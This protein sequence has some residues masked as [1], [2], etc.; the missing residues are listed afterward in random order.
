MA[1]FP[2]KMHLC[3]IVMQILL[4]GREMPA[5]NLARDPRGHVRKGKGCTDEPEARVFK[6]GIPSQDT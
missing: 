2:D 5:D 1:Q 3:T 4:K 6:N